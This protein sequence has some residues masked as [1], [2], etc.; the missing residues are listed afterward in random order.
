LEASKRFKHTMSRDTP[1]KL[2]SAA[3]RRELNDQEEA[4]DSDNSAIDLTLNA[5]GTDGDSDEDSPQPP[6][7]G[8]GVPEDTTMKA[9]K[10][11]EDIKSPKPHRSLDPAHY[12]R[13]TGPRIYQRHVE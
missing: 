3:K 1:S 12:P 9:G 10:E 5:M 7:N 11:I 8:K 13:G 2:E 6:S 4:S